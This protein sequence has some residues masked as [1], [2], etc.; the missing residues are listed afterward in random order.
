MCRHQVTCSSKPGVGGIFSF[1]ATFVAALELPNLNY[2][3]G[4][5]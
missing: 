2:V 1:T 5:N 3:Q 4:L